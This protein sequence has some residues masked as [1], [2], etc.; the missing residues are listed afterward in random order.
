MKIEINDIIINSLI[1]LY[2]KKG[3]R[4]VSGK[5]INRYSMK[6]INY[7]IERRKEDSLE[8]NSEDWEK[9][10]MSKKLPYAVIEENGRKI[11]MIKENFAV[12]DLKEIRKS[13][14]I[15]SLEEMLVFNN[16]E[17][18]EALGIVINKDKREPL[19]ETDFLELFF[20][21]LAKTGNESNNNPKAYL[22]N[23]YLKIFGIIL[24]HNMDWKDEYSCLL[25]VKKYIS[26]L[27][28][29]E[30]DFEKALNI[31]TYNNEGKVDFEIY[32][33]QKTIKLSNEEISK[34]VSKYDEETI[35]KMTNFVLLYNNIIFQEER[36][37]EMMIIQKRINQRYGFD[38]NHEK[39]KV[40]IN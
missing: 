14:G 15:P 2:E 9:I 5:T 37:E 22:K 40:K 19:D 31:Y 4:S 27:Y 23:N 16:E 24:E 6:V 32:N 8:I 34:I 13:K 38:S 29:F 36:R 3:I 39:Q 12:E 11:I 1:L 18:L 20:A 28:K 26:D 30:T 21:I 17:A 35:E 25:N 7:L 33:K 10:K